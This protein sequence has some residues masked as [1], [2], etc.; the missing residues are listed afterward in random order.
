MLCGLVLCFWGLRPT[1][2][3]CLLVFIVMMMMMMMII[4]TTGPPGLCSC[5]ELLF[6][7]RDRIASF[8]SR[9][10]VHTSRLGHDLTNLIQVLINLIQ[11]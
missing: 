4:R 3:V 11:V 9:K 5:G 6:G 2:E 10:K 1:V 8:G 7:D